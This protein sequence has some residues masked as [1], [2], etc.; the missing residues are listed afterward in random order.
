MS[1]ELNIRKECCDIWINLK[2][3]TKMI[4]Y[5]IE[6]KRQ[7]SDLEA[8]LAES[9]KEVN[10]FKSMKNREQLIKEN[11]ALKD[12]ISVVLSQKSEWIKSCNEL[13]QQLSEK[14]KEIES[15]RENSLSKRI[16]KEKLIPS[17]CMEQY[18]KYE[19]QIDKLTQDKIS[20]AVEQLE[21]V[22]DWANDYYG[23]YSASVITNYIDNQI[24]QLKGK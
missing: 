7:I 24:K 8:K 2:D 10:R 17:H 4:D 19:Q 21:K 23:E 13:K 22:K 14:E 16:F 5:L 20:F 18:E 1:K 12:T 11:E 6:S 3:K 9:E 15:L